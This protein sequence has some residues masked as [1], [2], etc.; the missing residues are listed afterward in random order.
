MAYLGQSVVVALPARQAQRYNDEFPANPAIE[1]NTV[2]P[3][4]VVGL[5]AEAETANV[6]FYHDGPQ[7]HY[8][9]NVPWA[10]LQDPTSVKTPEKEDVPVEDTAAKTPKEAATRAWDPTQEGNG[11]TY[12]GDGPGAKAAPQ[13]V[14]QPPA[15]G[16]PVAGVPSNPVGGLGTPVDSTGDDWNTGKE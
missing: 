12:E 5:N 2:R 6:V 13:P 10:A 16:S 11:T 4:V 15:P 14:P 1:P 3:G 7:T 9:A 8:V